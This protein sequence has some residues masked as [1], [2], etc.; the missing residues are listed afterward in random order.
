MQ[1]PFPSAMPAFFSDF[2]HLAKKAALTEAVSLGKLAEL[3]GTSVVEAKRR[4]PTSGLRIPD[5]LAQFGLVH[6]LAAR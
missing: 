1:G 2:D 5:E 4:K 3:L 6:S